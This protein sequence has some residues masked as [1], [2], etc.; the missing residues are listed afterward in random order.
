MFILLTQTFVLDS[1]KDTHTHTKP[2]KRGMVRTWMNTLHRGRERERNKLNS[3]KRLK[4]TGACWHLVLVIKRDHTGTPMQRRIHIREESKNRHRS[5]KQ[6]IE[7]SKQNCHNLDGRVWSIKDKQTKKRWK[8][9][10]LQGD[11]SHLFKLS[12]QFTTLKTTLFFIQTGKRVPTERRSNLAAFLVCDLGALRFFFKHMKRMTRMLVTL[13]KPV[14]VMIIVKQCFLMSLGWGGDLK[15]YVT[16]G[17]GG[18][19]F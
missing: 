6:G 5:N 16:R 12:Q 13:V 8:L 3:N 1:K 17:G 2:P 19:Y 9:L 10:T 18:V 11:R 7:K 14:S 4:Y 15:T